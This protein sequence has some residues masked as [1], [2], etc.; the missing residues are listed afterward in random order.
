[1]ELQN[2][3]KMIK[4]IENEKCFEDLQF[5]ALYRISATWKR[6]ICSVL[7][8]GRCHPYHRENAD[9]TVWSLFGEFPGLVRRVLRCWPGK[10]VLNA[11]S[12]TFE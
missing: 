3:L 2:F 6:E 4:K 5:P 10:S 7:G 9:K 1:M 11:P 12:R 8:E